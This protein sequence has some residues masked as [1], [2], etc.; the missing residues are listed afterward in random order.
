MRVKTALLLQKWQE[1]QLFRRIARWEAREKPLNCHF[2]SAEG[3][4]DATEM[5][6]MRRIVLLLPPPRKGTIAVQ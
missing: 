4:A 6:Q 3:S 2:V 1:L 5:T